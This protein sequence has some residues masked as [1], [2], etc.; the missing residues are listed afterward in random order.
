[1]S[2]PAG[3]PIDILAAIEAVVEAAIAIDAGGTCP[4]CAA[5]ESVAERAVALAV[6]AARPSRYA[7]RLL[8]EL[9][10][11]PAAAARAFGCSLGAVLVWRAVD[12]AERA[13]RRALDA[14]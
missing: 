11:D 8:D 13:G 14:A 2:A 5:S 3:T 10:A 12:R 4:A 1:M 6:P 7:V 9:R